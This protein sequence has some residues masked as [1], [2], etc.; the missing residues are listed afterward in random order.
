MSS[1]RK[2]LRI[3]KDDNKRK[4]KERDSYTETQ[5]LTAAVLPISGGTKQ[6]INKIPE[7]QP[8]K[9]E[10]DVIQRATT[11]T[12]LLSKH[13]S[14]NQAMSEK[15]DSKVK[16]DQTVYTRAEHREKE[17]TPI[18]VERS[19]TAQNFDQRTTCKGTVSSSL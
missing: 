5:N 19:S 10:P 6:K 17:R 14:G 18:N 4:H 8:R 3:K 2:F 16:G 9:S 11:S 7:D 13:E 1:I 12:S 15:I